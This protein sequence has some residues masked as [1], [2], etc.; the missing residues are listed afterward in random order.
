MNINYC[1]EADDLEVALAQFRRS[2]HN[3]EHVAVAAAT[4]QLQAAID[5]AEEAAKE[6]DAGWLRF[7][8]EQQQ[9]YLR[10]ATRIAVARQAVKKHELG[11]G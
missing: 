2:L 3:G 5:K 7:P 9:G 1:H 8:R 4:E 6:A 10:L 11:S